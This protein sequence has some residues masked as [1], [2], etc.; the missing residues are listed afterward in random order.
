M[1]KIFLIGDEDTVLGFRFAGIRGRVAKDSSQ[2]ADLFTKAVQDSEV[3][4]VVVTERIAQLVRPQIDVFMEKHDLPFV[5][6]IAD[7]AG[8]IPTR[9]SPSDIV[10]EAIGISI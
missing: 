7:S 9:K 6:E 8:P 1:A 3:S 2:A 5:V 10:R 4:I